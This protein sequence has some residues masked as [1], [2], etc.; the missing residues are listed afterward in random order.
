MQSLAFVTPE[1]MSRVPS[2]RKP[3]IHTISLGVTHPP[4]TPSCTAPSLIYFALAVPV[5]KSG[6]ARAS[7]ATH[8]NKFFFT[9]M[10][11]L[12]LKCLGFSTPVKPGFLRPDNYLLRTSLHCLFF[13][14][15]SW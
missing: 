15:V 3:T 5:S 7:T 1:A 11:L 9:Y 4:D 8:S 6:S 10:L 13:G 14:L 2:V 12:L